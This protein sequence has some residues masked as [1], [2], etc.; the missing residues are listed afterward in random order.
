MGTRQALNENVRSIL[1][2]VPVRAMMTHSS[3]KCVT[4]FWCSSG[5]AVGRLMGSIN[6]PIP[7]AIYR[8]GYESGYF[9]S[10]EGSQAT[11]KMA[12]PTRT[13]AMLYK[14]IEEI[15]VHRLQKAAYV[16]R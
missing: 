12:M 7:K 4:N 2:P 9:S 6:T 3:D 8:M 13:R 5:S 14:D 11:P 1:R 16:K 15:T 10:K